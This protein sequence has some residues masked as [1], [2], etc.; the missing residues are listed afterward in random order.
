[1][2]T[3]IYKPLKTKIVCFDDLSEQYQAAIEEAVT[4]GGTEPSVHIDRVRIETYRAKD[5]QHLVEGIWQWDTTLDD[6]KGDDLE[7]V[8]YIIK[9]A[10]KEGFWPYISYHAA[11]IEE[12]AKVEVEED[13]HRIVLNH[14][15]GW[16]RL[17]AAFVL[18]QRTIDIVFFEQTPPW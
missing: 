2:M 12:L 6:L 13:G 18:G 4:M 8:N 11:D 10:P 17:I 5:I 3:T 9:V 7:R 15:D 16:H 1:M 14:G